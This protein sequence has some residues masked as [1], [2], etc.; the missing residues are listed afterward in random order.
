MS[1][2]IDQKNYAIFISEKKQ[3]S[4]QSMQHDDVRI[5][6]PW[7]PSIGS[8]S[9]SKNDSLNPEETN[10]HFTST[11]DQTDAILTLGNCDNNYVEQ[12]KNNTSPTPQ[13][14]HTAK[15]VTT[16]H[17]TFNKPRTPSRQSIKSPTHHLTTHLPFTSPKTAKTQPSIQSKKKPA[18]VAKNDVSH[19]TKQKTLNSFPSKLSAFSPDPSP[20]KKADI[21]KH[22][23]P[24]SP[25][26]IPIQNKF[27]PLRKPKSNS[28][29]SSSLSGPLFPPGFESLIPSPI[30]KAHF[31]KKERKKKEEDL[32]TQPEAQ[33][34][35]SLSFS[36]QTT[37][38]NYITRYPKICR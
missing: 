31:K 30:K 36:Y 14:E 1:M 21:Q 2:E 10:S 34:N 35:L 4:R 27:E 17:A 28:I 16:S 13:M 37:H 12:P 3:F 24:P 29:S 25:I 22:G 32:K 23:P 11:P 26:P 9:P 33:T 38:P 20:I 8:P 7:Q 6:S 18:D 19:P 5:P 15:D